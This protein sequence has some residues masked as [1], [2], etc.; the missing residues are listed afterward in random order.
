M[1]NNSLLRNEMCQVSLQQL[2][3]ICRDCQ[4]N[5][6]SDNVTGAG[7]KSKTTLGVFFIRT[8]V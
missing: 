6:V 5:N 1:C 8:P 4:R 2:V 3:L 7:G